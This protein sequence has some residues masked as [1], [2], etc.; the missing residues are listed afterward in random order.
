MKHIFFIE[1]ELGEKLDHFH[2]YFFFTKLT[3]NLLFTYSLPWDQS[4]PLGYFGEVCV[5]TS[6][7]LIFWIVAPQILF[8]FVFLCKNNFIFAEMFVSFLD[9]FDEL[10]KQKIQ[11]KCDLLRKLIDFHNGIKR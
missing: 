10:H 2:K 1:F 5:A 8:L 6:N 9:E 7:E 3:N 11:Q 4:T